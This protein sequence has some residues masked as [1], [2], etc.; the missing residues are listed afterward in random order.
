MELV[1]SPQKQ[2]NSGYTMINF[3]NETYDQTY[4]LDPHTSGQKKLR[5]VTDFKLEN[6]ENLERIKLVVGGHLIFDYNAAQYKLFS[7]NELFVLKN[8]PLP[9]WHEPILHITNYK[10]MVCSYSIKVDNNIDALQHCGYYKYSCGDM[11]MLGG[12]IT[13]NKNVSKI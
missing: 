9:Y 6:L 1:S 3:H 13:Y 10:P 12:L 11:S 4:G 5:F 2:I 8:L 7:K